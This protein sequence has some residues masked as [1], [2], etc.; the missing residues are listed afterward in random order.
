MELPS[1]PAHRDGCDSSLGVSPLPSGSTP[2]SGI[3]LKC[4]IIIMKYPSSIPQASHGSETG[5]WKHREALQ[6]SGLLSR[7]CLWPPSL[8]VQR[9][10]LLP[11]GAGPPPRWPWLALSE[12]HRSATLT[13]LAPTPLPNSRSGKRPLSDQSRPNSREH[14]APCPPRVF[15]HTPA[16]TTLT[17]APPSLPPH[18]SSRRKASPTRGAACCR[19]TGDVLVCAGHTAGRQQAHNGATEEERVFNSISPTPSFIPNVIITIYNTECSSAREKHSSEIET[20]KIQK[21][22]KKVKNRKRLR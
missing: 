19:V 17:L 21:R 13:E 22:K 1:A 4:K 7:P 16:T 8:Q 5:V 18:L 10:R 15:T 20:L 3:F 9:A 12:L 6:D 14:C 11:G 2:G